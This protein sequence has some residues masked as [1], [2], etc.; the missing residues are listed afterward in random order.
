MDMAVEEQTGFDVN[1][2][3]DGQIQ[4]D[5]QDIGENATTLPAQPNKKAKKKNKRAA[6][7]QKLTESSIPVSPYSKSHNR[8]LKKK[9]KQSL[10][11]DSMTAALDD[12]MPSTS[13]SFNT[14]EF[15]T[16]TRPAGSTS[17]VSIAPP[18][19]SFLAK[20][21]R[22]E[23]KQLTQQQKT[24]TAPNKIGEDTVHKSMSARQRQKMLNEERNRLPAILAHKSFSAN[25]FETIRL[26][27]QN[28][29]V[30]LEKS[31]KP[32]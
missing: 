19:E 2:D 3:V 7:M 8:R 4:E 6:L 20:R 28:T 16:T 10:G 22:A 12:A 24:K 5:N 18:P 25:P 31:R 13:T 32:E 11:L 29:I 17:K 21:S 15:A 1:D 14:A 9:Q 30:P 23:N 26:H 27:A